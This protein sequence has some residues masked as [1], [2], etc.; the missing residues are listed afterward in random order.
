MSGSITPFFGHRG[1]E[2][3]EVA[4]HLPGWF[5]LGSIRSMAIRRPIGAPADAA[6]RLDVML[7]VAHPDG[8]GESSA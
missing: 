3:G 5:G 2:L 6:Q 8:F 7:V 4:H 1:H